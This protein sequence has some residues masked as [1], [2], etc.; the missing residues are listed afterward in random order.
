MADSAL[1]STCEKMYDSL[2]E[3]R[4]RSFMAADYWERSLKQVRLT[5]KTTVQFPD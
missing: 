3:N 5:I 2:S 4:E 1:S